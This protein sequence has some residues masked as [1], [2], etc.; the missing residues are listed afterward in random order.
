MKRKKP[1]NLRLLV[2]KDLESK[3]WVVGVVERQCG[4]IKRDLF[5]VA[6]LLAFVPDYLPGDIGVALVQVTSKEHRLDHLK[7]INDS[8]FANQGWVY[9]PQRRFLLACVTKDGLIEW[10]ERSFDGTWYGVDLT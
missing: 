7:K 5:G 3:G 4:P 9:R 2:Q 8:K 10:D 1:R 6:D